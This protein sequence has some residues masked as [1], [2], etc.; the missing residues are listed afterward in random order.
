M[1]IVIIFDNPYLLLSMTIFEPGLLKRYF[2]CDSPKINIFNFSFSVCRPS[3]SQWTPNPPPFRSTV[4]CWF[5]SA[6]SPRCPPPCCRWKTPTVRLSGWSSSS[7]RARVTDGWCCSE[8]R[9]QEKGRKAGGRQVESWPGMT[10]S[11]GR[12]WELAGSGSDTK[13]TKPGQWVRCGSVG[14]GG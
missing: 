8:A 11:P 1:I 4:P 3:T 7:S 10:P 12:S 9:R 2:A 6:V 14:G 5:P 13:K